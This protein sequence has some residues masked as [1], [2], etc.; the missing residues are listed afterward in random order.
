MRS[1]RLVTTRTTS[2]A[3]IT[4]DG[5]GRQAYAGK[6]RSVLVIRDDRFD[7][8]S[9]VTVCPLT[10]DPTEIP[11]LRIPLHPSDINGLAAPNSIMLDKVTTMPRSKLGERIG[12][13]SNA[14]MLALARGLVVFL[15]LA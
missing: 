6:P 10:S 14:E 15:D 11:L 7:A 13:V 2:E 8:T 5:R 1:R 4:L 9:S 12:K 3:G